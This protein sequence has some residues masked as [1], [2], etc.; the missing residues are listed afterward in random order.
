LPV[1]HAAALE[2]V[3]ARVHVARHWIVPGLRPPDPVPGLAAGRGSTAAAPPGR[4]DSAGPAAIVAVDLVA[5]RVGACGR[6]Y[7]AVLRLPGSALLRADQSDRHRDEA[8]CAL[9]LDRAGR[10]PGRGLAAGSPAS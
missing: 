4:A 8:G 5:D 7:P 9:P 6:V 1:A 2:L 10:L 3:A